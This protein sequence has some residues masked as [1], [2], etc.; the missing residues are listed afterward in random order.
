[1]QTNAKKPRSFLSFMASDCSFYAYHKD[2]IAKDTTQLGCSH[3]EIKLG[4]N[5]KLSTG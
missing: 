1:M 2:P 4:R 5:W 3:K